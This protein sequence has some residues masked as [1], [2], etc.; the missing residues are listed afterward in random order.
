MLIL[1]GG[2]LLADMPWQKADELARALTAK[3]RAAETLAKVDGIAR[4]HAI[5]LRAGAPFGLT[6]NP[7]IRNMAARIAAWDRR[8][9]RYMPG[10]IKSE[11]HVGVP[12][13]IRHNPR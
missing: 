13:V 8:L 6:N 4:D 12:S 5:L 11:E 3:A 7:T 10:G 1:A 9:R 2:V